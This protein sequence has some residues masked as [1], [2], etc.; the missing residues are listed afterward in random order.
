MTERSF[1]I[2]REGFHICCGIFCRDIR[3]IDTLVIFCHGFAGH[4]SSAA[5]LR[6]AQ[7]LTDKHRRAALLTF[8]LP[9]H[10]EDVRKKLALSD[11]LDY[12]EQVVAYARETYRPKNLY[13]CGTSFGGFLLLDYAAARGNPF[14][15]IVLRCPAVDMYRIL[16]RTLLTPE[17]LGAL[18]RGKAVSVGFDRKIAIRQSFLE[19]L[20]QADLRKNDYLDWAEDILVLQGMADEIVSPDSVLEFCQDQLMECIPIAGADHR[21]RDPG[22][23]DLAIKETLNF[24]SMS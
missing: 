22:K 17:D 18:R 12:L 24:F 6:L 19:E 4:R 23:M 11:C 9:C 8:D 10:G 7:R 13:A 15:K 5:A 20:Q 2:N 21:F 16:T 1:Q 3:D 14:T